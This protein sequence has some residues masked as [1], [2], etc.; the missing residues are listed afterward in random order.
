MSLFAARLGR[1]R[2]GARVAHGGGHRAPGAGAGGA[3]RAVAALASR[4][5]RRSRSAPRSCG[6]PRSSGSPLT[7][8]P[9]GGS[10]YPRARGRARRCPS[11]PASA[12][13]R[14]SSR[15]TAASRSHLAT[16]CSPSRSRCAWSPTPPTDTGWLRW[17]T[18]L[19]WVEELRPFAG[20]AARGAAAP[21]LRR[22]AA[23]SRS[24]WPSR[25]GA[26]SAPGSCSAATPPSR[27]F[28]A[29]L[30]DCPGAARRAAARWSRWLVGLGAFALDHRRHLGQLRIG[31]VEQAAQRPREARRRLTADADGRAELLLPLLRARDQPVRE[32]AD[33]CGSARG[34]RAAARDAA[35]APG[36]AVAA[37]SLGR[38]LLAALGALALG[39]AAGLLAWAGA[40]S[41]GADVALSGMLEAGLNCLPAALLFLALA[42]LAF[43]AIPRETSPSRY[44][45]VLVAFLWE[46]VGA[47]VGRA[48]LDARALAV[49]SRR[50]RARPRV[51]ARGGPDDARHRR[52]RHGHR[53]GR[54]RTARSHG[55]LSLPIRACGYPAGR[56]GGLAD[57]RAHRAR[58]IVSVSEGYR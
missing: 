6:S 54:V 12:R 27:G 45:L 32:R 39:L 43:A 40:V 38:L 50:A 11:S 10:A 9:A 53:R 21:A 44:G 37:G 24:R 29:V 14:A 31:T 51:P 28:P 1:A 26:T 2:G 47:L 36:R 15:R 22:A 34:G 52:P 57:V 3:R 41:Q 49:P 56:L 18:P 5:S 58:Q 20:A 46:L 55:R 16:A 23:C 8:L 13:S 33:R 4:R 17:A 48:R 42:A 25:S 7:R 30:A 35:R 19:G